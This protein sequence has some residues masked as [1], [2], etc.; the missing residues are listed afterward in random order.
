MKGNERGFR[1]V[2]HKRQ[3][4]NA[5]VAEINMQQIR[6]AAAQNAVE[7][8]ILTAIKNRLHALDVFLIETRKK[9]DPRAGKDLDVGKGKDFDVLA[10]LGHHE[11]LKFSQ[12]GHLSINMPHL[13]LEEGIAVAGDD[14]LRHEVFE[15]I[16][17]RCVRQADF[18]SHLAALMV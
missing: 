14:W 2:T 8:V 13:A 12:S 6:M 3:Q 1:P 10:R 9:I 11:S 5:R 16:A 18:V 17:V 4:V 7:L 15:Q